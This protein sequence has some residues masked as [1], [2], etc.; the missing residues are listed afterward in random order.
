M[1][2]FFKELKE[3]IDPH[4]LYRRHLTRIRPSVSI[5]FLLHRSQCRL[6]LIKYVM[7]FSFTVHPILPDGLS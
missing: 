4:C 3:D 2:I 5:S 6:L 1:S 7:P